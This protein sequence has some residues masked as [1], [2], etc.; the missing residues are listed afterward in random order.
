MKHI[1]GLSVLLLLAGCA[2]PVSVAA[3]V[4]PV[5]PTPSS[6]SGTVQVRP[7]S[8]LKLPLG[9]VVDLDT[10]TVTVLAD[11]GA[12][13]G[14]WAMQVRT[15]I[16]PDYTQTKVSAKYKW[17]ASS[18]AG[19]QIEADDSSATG[20]YGAEVV[21]PGECSEGLIYFPTKTQPDRIWYAS[22]AGM[23]GWLTS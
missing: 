7:E 19:E 2:A 11:A 18:A 5:T 13:K 10:A 8:L 17:Y 1:A 12:R 6:Q 16:S 23:I 3:P 4:A 9:T 22:A 14:V 15:C 21:N 20:S